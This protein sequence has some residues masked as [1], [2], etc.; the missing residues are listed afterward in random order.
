MFIVRRT[1]VAQPGRR[2]ESVAVVK[3]MMAA[4]TKETGFPVQRI[5]T[6]SI[7][8]S[9]STIEME[10]AVATLAELDGHLEKMNSWSGAAAYQQKLAGLVVP[11]TGRFEIYRVQS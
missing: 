9:D 7:G 10:G 2:D 6:G 3:E 1:W 8:P 5:V 4:A 11:G